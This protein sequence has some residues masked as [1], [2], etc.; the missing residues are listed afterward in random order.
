MIRGGRGGPS[1]VKGESNSANR[2]DAYLEVLR[3]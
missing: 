2:E 1:K 3:S